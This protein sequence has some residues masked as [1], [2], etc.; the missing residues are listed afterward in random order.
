MLL[1]VFLT[2]VLRDAIC[3]VVVLCKADNDC[4]QASTGVVLSLLKASTIADNPSFTTDFK[5]FTP[6]SI[7][8]TLSLIY[9]IES[10]AFV[11]FV[12]ILFT[13]LAKR[14]IAP[15]KIVTPPAPIV[16][17]T[18]KAPVARST[19]PI[20]SAKPASVVVSVKSSGN[21]V[22]VSVDIVTIPCPILPNALATP[23]PD[24]A[25]VGKLLIK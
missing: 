18:P 11:A 17:V 22:I 23:S 1:I 2:D 24:S 5:P 15:A 10:D 7:T 19:P 21:T 13:D 12:A 20:A 16:A 4:V 8:D 25:S 3:V 9:L 14:A 6:D